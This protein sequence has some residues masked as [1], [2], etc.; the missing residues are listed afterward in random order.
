M[1]R[2][3]IGLI[4]LVVL[5]SCATHKSNPLSEYTDK[6]Q[7]SFELVKTQYKNVVFRACL[8]KA[9]NYSEAYRSF[10]KLDKSTPQDFPFGIYQYRYIDTIVQPIVAKAKVDSTELYSWYFEGM[11]EIERNELNGLPMI[12]YC[13]E[14]YVSEELDSIANQRVLQ[15][16]ALWRERK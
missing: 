12:K 3:L 4:T 6:E 8:S 2:I 9:Y 13:L 10:D 11:N 5:I 15:M 1:K 16:D 7:V 14:F